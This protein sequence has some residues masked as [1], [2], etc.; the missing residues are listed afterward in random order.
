MEDIKKF[1]TH[2]EQL[3][4]LSAIQEAEKNSS[5]EIR[6][7]VERSG[8][9][10]IMKSARKAFRKLDMTET[11]KRNGILFFFAVEDRAFAIIGDDGIDEAV[12]PTFWDDI[13][14]LMM[15]YFDHGYFAKGLTEGIKLTGFALKRHFPHQRD[16]VNELPDAI[17][18]EED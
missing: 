15:T 7:R 3:M 14:D 6:V 4:I 5:G 16:D 18:F 12:P 11:A 8:G 13:R 2:E 17:S 9:R 10:K 1:F